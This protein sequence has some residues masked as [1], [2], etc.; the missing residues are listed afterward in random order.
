MKMQ[1]QSQ[2]LLSEL[3]IQHCHDK[4]YRS[5]MQIPCGCGCGVG[6]PAAIALIQPLA[7]ELPYAAGAALKSK[8]Q[9]NKIHW[10][11]SSVESCAQCEPDPFV[12][13]SP[14]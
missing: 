5:K 12:M 14:K 11:P 1:V 8:K 9:T 10:R 6:Q 4:R 2:A 7:W 13:N 3:R